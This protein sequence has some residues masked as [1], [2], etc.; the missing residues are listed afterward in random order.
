MYF[1]CFYNTLFRGLEPKLY[2]FTILKT[3][4]YGKIIWGV[5][6]SFH[7]DPFQFS[8][9]LAFNSSRCVCLFVTHD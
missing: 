5:D 3:V 6:N 1:N 8:F 2:S 7:D 9:F 4:L